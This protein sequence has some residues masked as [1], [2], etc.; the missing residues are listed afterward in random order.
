MWGAA[1]EKSALKANA[2]VFWR[3]WWERSFATTGTDNRTADRA[4]LGFSTFA[5]A[6][7]FDELNAG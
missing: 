7:A 4:D 5:N 2:R 6:K 3:Y 1:S